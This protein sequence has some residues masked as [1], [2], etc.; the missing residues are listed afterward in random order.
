MTHF[1]TVAISGF[2]KSFTDLQRVIIEKIR[3]TKIP[4]STPT[5]TQLIV[6]HLV[7][8]LVYYLDTH[9][10]HLV[11]CS[12]PLT[13]IL[14]LVK[15]KTQTEKLPYKEATLN[16]RGGKLTQRW[17]IQFW[18]WDA[19]QN[20]TIRRWDYAVDREKGKD[21]ADTLRIRRA[22]AKARI[23][24]INQLLAEGYHMK[25][26]PIAEKVIDLT[27]KAG[28]N[29][30]LKI[31]GLK[32]NSYNSYSSTTNIFLE[33][34]R[35]NGFDTINLD[36]FKRKDAYQYIDWRI[37][38]GIKGSTINSDISYIKRLWSIL[39]KREIIQDNPFSGVEKQKEVRSLKNMAYTDAEI[40]VLK[41]EISVVDPELWSF[42]QIIYNTFIRPNELRQLK[43]SDIRLAERTIYIDAKISKNN[44]SEFV[45][46][47]D[48]LIDSIIDLVQNKTSGE[49]IF[50]GKT[51]AIS[52]N[53]MNDR[54][55]PFLVKHS[56]TKDHTLY[57]WKHTGVVR[58]YKAGVDLKRIQLQCRHHSIA[59][60]DTYLKSMGLYEN[61]EIK[62]KMP[63]L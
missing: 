5:L 12:V 8:F 6:I 42:I 36:K 17:Y 40:L 10:T 29:Y 32:G 22:Y 37:S 20:K 63:P 2:I 61:L 9:L 4:S 58:A 19:K 59:Q 50:P 15:M 11:F 1:D 16:D 18:V 27:V 47:P 55:R 31:S 49:F 54:H 53:R 48:S 26:E 23:R 24:A 34:A 13:S 38:C 3:K 28:M 45:T 25:N 44:K 43:V 14:K 33:W 39:R 35:A 57:S 52:K 21:D 56:F 41:E 60:T 30:A 62:L 46:I 51:G 7:G